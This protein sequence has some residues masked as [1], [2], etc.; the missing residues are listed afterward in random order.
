[1]IPTTEDERHFWK[2]IYVAIISLSGHG[3]ASAIE[4]ADIAVQHYREFC[5]KQD[6]QRREAHADKHL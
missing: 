3:H 6:Q 1:M 5:Q 2:T 4:H